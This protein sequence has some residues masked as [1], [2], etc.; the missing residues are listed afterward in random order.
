MGTPDV[1]FMLPFLKSVLPYRVWFE[2]TC[3][4]C[5][6]I[7]IGSTFGLLP[8]CEFKNMDFE[9]IAM[10]IDWAIFLKKLLAKTTEDF[11]DSSRLEFLER[12]SFVL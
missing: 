11:R 1:L 8:R 7:F 4:D 6:G 2:E 3:C 10:G 5:I 9:G 12:D